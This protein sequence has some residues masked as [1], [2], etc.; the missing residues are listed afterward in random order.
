ML[1]KSTSHSPYH[2]TEGKDQL[3]TPSPSLREDNFAQKLERLVQS[4]S[5]TTNNSALKTVYRSTVQNDSMR[6][7]A[8]CSNLPSLKHVTHPFHPILFSVL[9]V[10]SLVLAVHLPCTQTR[11]LSNHIE[12]YRVCCIRCSH[13]RRTRKKGEWKKKSE[14]AWDKAASGKGGGRADNRG[15]PGRRN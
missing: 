4:G 8:D 5:S 12:D 11:Q 3:Y 13:R 2:T 15:S 9:P 7:T 6:H 1:F 10:T 14:R